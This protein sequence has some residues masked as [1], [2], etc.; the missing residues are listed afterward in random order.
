LKNF[1]NYAGL[2]SSSLCQQFAILSPHV[3]IGGNP[4]VS[5]SASFFEMG[6]A[7]KW[8]FLFLQEKR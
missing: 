2:S 3:V 8:L 5:C 1:S 7:G 4:L 6:L